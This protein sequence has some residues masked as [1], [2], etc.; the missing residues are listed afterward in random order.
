MRVSRYLVIFLITT[1][2]IF[3]QSVTVLVTPTRVEI[4]DT[5]RYSMTL[6]YL[7]PVKLVS[8]PT[9]QLFTTLSPDI[10][11][12]DYHFNKVWLYCQPYFE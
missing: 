6:H 2:T 1:T 7:P 12:I 4:G 9:K 3:A 5:V 11:L 10:Q 8:I